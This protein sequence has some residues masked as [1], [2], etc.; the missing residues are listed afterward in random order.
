MDIGKLRSEY[1]NNGYFK[2]S[3]FFKKEI[4]Q[5]LNF[6]IQDIVCKKPKKIYFYSD[7]NNLI[8]RMEHFY[9]YTDLL[10]KI[11]ND[12]LEFLEQIFEKKFF[13]FKDKYNFKPPKGEGFFSHYDGV[14][15][16][17]D[18]K[19]NLR[20]GWYEYADTFINVLI[21]LNNFEDNNGPLE[22]A[23]AHKGTF[24][25][26]L[27]NTKENGTPDI[28]NNLKNS[29][30]FTKMIC[31]SGSIVVFSSKCPHRSSKNKS[32]NNRGSLYYTYNPSEFGNKYNLYFEEKKTSKNSQSKSLSGEID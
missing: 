3:N 4:I 17:K 30:Y 25:E 14:F 6:E 24:E 26:L 21:T 15:K 27:K 11:N 13:L 22:V 10:K 31:P 7:R 9:D 32:A 20:N 19:G 23:K 28:K 8:R 16:W 29:Y 18:E 12:I 1:K 2:V 5:D